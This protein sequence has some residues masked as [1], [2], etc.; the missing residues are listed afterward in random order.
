VGR[1]LGGRAVA[2]KLEA[3]RNALYDYYGAINELKVLL[4]SQPHTLPNI[5]IPEKPEALKLWE[6]CNTMN[7]PLYDGGVMDQPHIWL[8]EW[9]IVKEVHDLFQP[10]KK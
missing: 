6:Q 4:E 2:A 10:E 9:A 8:E 5:V 1:P 7:L 3:L